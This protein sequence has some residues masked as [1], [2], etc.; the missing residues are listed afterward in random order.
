M[1]DKSYILNYSDTA[2][3][4]E[5]GEFLKAKRLEQNLTQEEVA[6]KAAMS[7]STL[8][9]V[10]RGEGISL[11]NLLK[12]LRILDALYVLESFR[13]ETQISPLLLAKEEENKRKRASKNYNQSKNEDIGW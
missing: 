4:K 1:N 10:E 2:I 7:R 11:I 3:L 5:I 9:L 6:T 8:S 12:I 13:L